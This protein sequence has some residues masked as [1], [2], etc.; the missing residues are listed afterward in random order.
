MGMGMRV[1]ARDKSR[2]GA[3]DLVK[4]HATGLSVLGFDFRGR[5]EFSIVCDASL[6]QRYTWFSYE[7]LH[8]H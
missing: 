4:L 1:M 5:L 6:I 8:H 2:M 7:L 3:E